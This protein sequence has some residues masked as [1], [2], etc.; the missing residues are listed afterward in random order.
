MVVEG[1]V[2]VAVVRSLIGFE[3]ETERRMSRDSGIEVEVEDTIV[4][5]RSSSI[6]VEVEV[7][8]EGLVVI[9]TENSEKD[10][11]EAVVD[12]KRVLEEGKVVLWPVAVVDIVVGIAVAAVS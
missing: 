9:G 3:T 8:K 11:I 5:G 4:V 6:E 10:R 2:A 1:L 7:G 12:N